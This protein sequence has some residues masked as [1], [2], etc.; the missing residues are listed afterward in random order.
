MHITKK[1]NLPDEIRNPHGENVQEILG[2]Q[3]GGV[4]RHSLARVTITPG[5]SS[6]PHYHKESEES[7]L[8]LSGKAVMAI[9][10][11]EFELTPGEAVLIEPPEVHRIWN[12]GPEDLVFIAVCVP[13]W[14]PQ[15]SFEIN[16]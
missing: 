11:Q 13:A 16:S 2:V 15:D 8:I 7:Y 3:A 6:L 12:P 14:Q 1:T 9:D 5:K 10:S 4:E